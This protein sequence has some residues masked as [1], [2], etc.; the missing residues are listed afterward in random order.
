MACEYELGDND[1]ARDAVG[2]LR[3]VDRKRSRTIAIHGIRSCLV[4][5]EPCDIVS[6]RY[7]WGV[8]ARLGL[9][10]AYAVENDTTRARAAY[11]EFLTLWKDAAADIPILKQAQAEYAKLRL[12]L[13][14]LREPR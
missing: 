5:M 4:D 11:D 3:K 12:A 6:G 8:P 14:P 9:G 2:E 10:R 7:P 1:R 13:P